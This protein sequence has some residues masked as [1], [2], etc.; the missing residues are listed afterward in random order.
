M[1]KSELY[2]RFTKKSAENVAHDGRK[3]KWG[4][5]D[6]WNSVRIKALLEEI[7]EAYKTFE[8]EYELTEED[9]TAISLKGCDGWILSEA[10]RNQFK[11]EYD[12]RDFGGVKIGKNFAK[13]EELAQLLV[14]VMTPYN[15]KLIYGDML[16]EGYETGCKCVREDREN[17]TRVSFREEGKVFRLK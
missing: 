10:L 7:V 2:E 17:F 9:K 12:P 1:P 4:M 13:K 14:E 8:E 3:N 5:E 15:D 11:I 16:A 6:Y